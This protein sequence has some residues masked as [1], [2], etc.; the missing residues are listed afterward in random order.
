MKE[1]G[2]QIIDR[3]YCPIELIRLIDE[4]S[5]RPGGEGCVHKRKRF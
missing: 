2:K 1:V 4:T 3:Y 5:R